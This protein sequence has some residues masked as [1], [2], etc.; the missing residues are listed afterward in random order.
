MLNRILQITNE[1]D[2]SIFLFGARQTGK[3][4]LLRQQLSETIYIDL[5]DTSVKDR[6]NRHPVLLYE[7][8][9]DKPAETLVIIDEIPEVPELLNEVHRLISE[10]H[11]QFILCGS[12][13]RKLKRKGHNTLGGRALPVYLY[14]L[15]SSEIPDFDIDRAVTF[16]MLPS[17]YLAKNPWRHLSAYI[18]VYLKEE[19]KEEALVRNLSAFQR[20]LEVA[21]LTDGEMVNLNNIAQDCGV[22]STTVSSYFDILEDTLIGYRIPAFAKAM[23]RRLVQAPRFYFFDIGVT[24]YL[25]HRQELRRG[26][27]GYGHAFEHLVIQELV[28]W[29]HYTHSEETLSYWRTYTGLEVD[30][31]IGNARVAIEVKSSEE[32]KPRHLKGLKAFGEEHPLC[33]KI[34]VSLDV[35]NRHIDDIECF[36]IKDFFNL[37]WSEG[38]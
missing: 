30:A 21:A 15:V 32:I 31:V 24:N 36:Y 5:L 6:F 1:L 14:P 11:L 7:M 20:F 26:T 8:L 3:S 18:Q 35:F 12:S 19:I 9:K 2:G 25:L 37:L 27:E 10:Y 28:A 38:L 33:R 17:H 13:A 23:K 4:T 16:G 22:S 34:I 29:L